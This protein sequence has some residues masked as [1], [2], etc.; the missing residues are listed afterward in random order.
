V[1]SNRLTLSVRTPKSAVFSLRSEPIMD[2]FYAEVTARTNLCSGSDE[3]GMIFRASPG[4]NYYRYVLACDGTVHLEIVRNAQKSPLSEPLPSGDAPPGAPGEVRLGVW[5][6]GTELRFFLNGR[7]QFSVFDRTFSN[8]T[9]GF[10]A[11]SNGENPLSVNFSDLTVSAVSFA[12][13]TPTVTPSITP[14][15]TRTP[16]AT[17]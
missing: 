8:G 12:S 5:A 9:L 14:K 16:R 7:Y 17:P 2:N 6:S 11:R 1:E 10:F 15:P 3:Y 13:P 4:N